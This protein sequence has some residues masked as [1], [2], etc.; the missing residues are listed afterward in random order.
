MSTL[1][2]KFCIKTHFIV[3]RHH[4]ITLVSIFGV[5]HVGVFALDALVAP[6]LLSGIL[7][8]AGCLARG[9][10]LRVVP[11]VALLTRHGVTDIAVS[12]AFA[13]EV[14]KKRILYVK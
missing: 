7:A 11:A 2:N 4:L 12:V 6:A 8:G 9:V 1:T 3:S 13:S 5:A 10:A 14:K